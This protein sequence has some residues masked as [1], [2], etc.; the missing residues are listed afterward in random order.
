V[1]IKDYGVKL[2]R[3][4]SFEFLVGKTEGRNEEKGAG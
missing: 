1:R 2:F 3:V 4:L